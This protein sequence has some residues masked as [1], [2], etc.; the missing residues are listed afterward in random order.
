MDRYDVGELAGLAGLTVFAG[1]LWPQAA[2]LVGSLLLLVEVQ[3]RS[4]GRAP[5]RARGTSRVGRVVRAVR[6]A[7][8]DDEARAA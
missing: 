5:V 2:L 7:W 3:L 4:R 1:L 8:T 6:A